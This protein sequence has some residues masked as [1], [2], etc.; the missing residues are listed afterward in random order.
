VGGKKTW[1]RFWREKKGVKWVDPGAK[2][3]FVVGGL[4]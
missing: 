3:Q 2:V 4:N 1:T